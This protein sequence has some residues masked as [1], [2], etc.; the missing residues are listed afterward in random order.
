M[1]YSKTSFGRAHP[2]VKLK[3]VKTGGCSMT[4]HS[5]GQVVSLL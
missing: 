3:V 2:F 5:L 4:G 1:S